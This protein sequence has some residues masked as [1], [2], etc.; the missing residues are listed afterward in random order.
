MLRNQRIQNRREHRLQLP[1]SQEKVAYLV[2]I[3]GFSCD[4]AKRSSLI[5]HAAGAPLPTM[6][7]VT[8][9]SQSTLTIFSK[10]L[11]MR[12][13][14]LSAVTHQASKH[15]TTKF[16]FQLAKG[17]YPYVARA[18]LC[19]A[20]PCD[21]NQ[22]VDYTR[23]ELDLHFGRM[24]GTGIASLKANRQG[25]ETGTTDELTARAKLRKW[26]NVKHIYEP[27]TSRTRPKSLFKPNVGFEN[28]QNIKAPS[29]L[30]RKPT[31]RSCRN[32]KGAQRHKSF[33]DV[34]TKLQSVGVDCERN[35]YQQ[36]YQRIRR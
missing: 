2:Y 25:E 3:M 28:P 29:G 22:G 17:G 24:N 7:K 13:D 26:D 31:L 21:R 32:A 27:F 36:S 5:R 16:Q 1:S 34:R 20:P 30:S 18:T 4:A 6:S 8:A 15:T 23:T 19:Y 33:R 14:L 11:T 35:Q 9:L 10:P 12:F